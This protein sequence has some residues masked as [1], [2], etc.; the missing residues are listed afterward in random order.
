MKEIKEK[1]SLYQIN[2]K[3]MDGSKGGAPEGCGCACHY[4]NCGGSSSGDNFDAN[5]FNH[6]TSTGPGCE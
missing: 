4:V 3:E 1:M 6:F 2:S 5:L